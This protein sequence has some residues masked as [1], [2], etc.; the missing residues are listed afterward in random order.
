[1]EDKIGAVQLL[2]DRFSAIGSSA[3]P[4]PTA[5]CEEGLRFGDYFLTELENLPFYLGNGESPLP[6]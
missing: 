4:I 1:M 3:R 2:Q 5:V 6:V